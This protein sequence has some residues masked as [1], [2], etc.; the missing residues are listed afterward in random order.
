MALP[1]SDEER[2]LYA[3]IVLHEHDE[4]TSESL[5]GAVAAL[6]RRQLERRKRDV[7]A[8]I[9]EAERRQDTA[10]IAQLLR[11]Q[12]EIE[13]ALAPRMQP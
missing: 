1:L 13:R 9:A 5:E 12:V 8:Q 10:G 4:L 2:R 3:D 11:E 7:R 6:R